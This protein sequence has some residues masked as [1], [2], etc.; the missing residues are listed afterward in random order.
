MLHAELEVKVLGTS[1]G[2]GDWNFGVMLLNMVGCQNYRPC[3]QNRGALK[4]EAVLSWGPQGVDSPAQDVLA[5]ILRIQDCKEHYLST[6]AKPSLSFQLITSPTPRTGILIQLEQFGILFPHHFIE[7][8]PRLPQK[9][10][11]PL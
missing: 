11:P 1:L 5:S 3:P 10:F 8:R 9:P 2:L 4:I 6:F 7:M